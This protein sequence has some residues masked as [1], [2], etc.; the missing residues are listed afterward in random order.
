MLTCPAW[1]DVPG[2]R[3]GFLDAT[4]CRP[5]ATDWAAVVARAAGP[6]RVLTL[7]QVH[8]CRV[9]TAE[10]LADQQGPD[11]TAARPEADG[12]ATALRG[13]ALGVVTADCVPVLLLARRAGIVAAVHAGWRGAAA[14]V[15]EATVR[16]LRERFGVDPASLEAC[17]GPAIGPCCYR[18]GPEVREAF[19]RRTGGKTGAAWLRV[20]TALHLDLRRAARC[21]LQDAGVR[22]VDRVGPCT[23]C[24]PAFSSYR[25]D[26]AA[27]GRQLS[28]IGWA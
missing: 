3:H 7:R 8:G 23:A 10:D 13:V 4:V 21:L 12:V 16:H 18:I 15:L 6:L 9:V 1:R 19:V 22:T 24:T 17:L 20:G 5:G 25:R 27:A 28:F 11:P 14:G 2:L 26:G